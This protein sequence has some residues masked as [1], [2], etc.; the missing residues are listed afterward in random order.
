M[1]QYG[2]LVD[3][4]LPQ[5]ANIPWAYIQSKTDACQKAYYDALAVSF[6]KTQKTITSQ[7][8]YEGVNG[9]FGDYNGRATN[10]LT[11]LVDGDQHC[12]T[13]FDLWYEATALGPHGA[14]MSAGK[15]VHAGSGKSTADKALYEWSTQF[16]LPEAA[17]AI[18]ECDG[19]VETAAQAGRDTSYCDPTVVPKTFTQ[20]W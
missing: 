6:N 3:A 20:H 14:D 1:K 8:F 16:P 10:F 9:I 11:F 19:E 15:L 5:H 4:C 12:F 18:T 7:Q 13:V 2:D 17:Q